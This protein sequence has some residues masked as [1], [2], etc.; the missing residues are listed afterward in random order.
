MAEGF[1]EIV[2]KGPSAAVRGFVVGILLSKGL[3]PD[4]VLVANDL[5]VSSDTFSQRMYEWIGMQNITHL[6]VPGNLYGDMQSLLRHAEE[7][8]GLQIRSDKP[9]TSASVPFSYETYNR[10][11]AD[12][13]QK[14]I[15]QLKGDLQ[16][17]AD[18]EPFQFE[19]PA[20]E[21]TELYSP[22]HEFEATGEGKFTGG[23]L[24]VLSAHKKLNE[25]RL[26]TVSQI[27]LNHPDD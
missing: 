21:G 2:V 23:L 22:A 10:K 7:V 25:H 11:N 16:L 26:F 15:E 24:A 14:F 1:H 5:P 9:I 8:L 6:L 4:T 18:F 27:E 13:I 20:A 12:E 3:A 19:D 17:N